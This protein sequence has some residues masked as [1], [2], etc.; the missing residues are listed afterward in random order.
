MTTL[1]SGGKF[2]AKVYQT[3][4]G[5]HGVGVSVVNALA[6][7]LEVE[8]ARNRELWRQS[9]RARPADRPARAG[10][11]APQPPGH[12]GPLA[13]RSGDLRPGAR[14]SARRWCTAWRAARPIC[15]AASRS[16]G[17]AIRSWSRAPTCRRARCSISRPG[18]RT[19]SRRRSRSGPASPS[20]R[21][22]AR[23]S[24]ATAAAGSNG[25]S[26]GRSTRSPTRPLL[27][28][29]ADPAGRLPRAGAAQRLFCARCAPTAS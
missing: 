20:C 23:P 4:G 28:H 13:A 5:L 10:R 11:P 29:R 18:S 19:S 8:V 25:R 27:Q 3:A 14:S 12:D 2:G 16:A 6:E 15:S 24:S 1:H 7:E 9:Y 22:S 26:P 17:S 21:S